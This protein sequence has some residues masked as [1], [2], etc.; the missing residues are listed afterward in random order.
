[1][2]LIRLFL[3]IAEISPASY[4]GGFLGC[5]FIANYLGISIA[6]WLDFGFAYIDDGNSVVRWRFLLAFQCFP[7]LLSLAG[8]ELLPDSP[9]YCV[10]VGEHEQAKEILEHIRGGTGSGVE[11]EFIES[12]AVAGQAKP[13][14]PIQFMR[15]LMGKATEA[16]HLGRRA[17]LCLW[18]QIMTSWTGITAVTAHSPVVGMLSATNI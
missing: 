14:S 7:A 13:S 15:I 8:V 6:Y 17:W 3:D 12:C 4:R 11:K 2:V 10:S 16:P 9:R 1:M 18:L 5:A